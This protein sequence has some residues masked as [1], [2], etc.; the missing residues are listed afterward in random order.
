MCKYCTEDA[1]PFNT[2]VDRTE[3][4]P[5]GNISLS[6]DMLF[7]PKWDDS[8]DGI[9][10]EASF[11]YEDTGVSF[12]KS[13]QIHYCPMC[14]R[15]LNESYTPSEDA[16]RRCETCYFHNNDTDQCSNED[17][18][19]DFTLKLFRCNEWCTLE[20]KMEK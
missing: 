2:I 17:S 1:F 11:C 6:L 16:Q 14:G 8:Y 15:K 5:L 7:D 20:Q 10:L 3:K 18:P 13:V 4:T 12:S 19:Y 9:A